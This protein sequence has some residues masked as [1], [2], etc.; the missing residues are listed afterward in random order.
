MSVFARWPAQAA[1]GSDD[2]GPVAQ[3]G[4]LVRNLSGAP[5]T[6]IQKAEADCQQAFLPAGIKV[7]WINAAADATWEGP[8]IV[9]RAA[10][11]P[12]APRS[13]GM[14][15]FGSALPNKRDGFQMFVYYDRVIEL[16]RRAELAV[17]L[18]LS[19]ALTHELGHMLL[20]SANHSV[21][22]VMRGE[23]SKRDLEELGQGL[24]RFT[25][26][27]KQQMSRTSTPK[28]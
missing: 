5:G 21:A 12:R 28:Q 2:P 16:S 23:W 11:L 26:Q 10:I 6:I 13:R 14:D 27:Q 1:N 4:V 17:H 9:L 7:S 22:G 24:L 15:V 19:G 3:V 18:V 20:R 25:P 8:D